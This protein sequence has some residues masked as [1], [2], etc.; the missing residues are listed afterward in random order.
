MTES[1]YEKIKR[2]VEAYLR[3]E[4]GKRFLQA[5]KKDAAPSLGA[6]AV[7]T[8]FLHFLKGVP[9]LVKLVPT[10]LL[11]SVFQYILRDKGLIR[12]EDD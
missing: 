10:A 6:A 12:E 9:Y 11:F 5:L 4:R 2:S 3:S 1:Y 8:M 7:A